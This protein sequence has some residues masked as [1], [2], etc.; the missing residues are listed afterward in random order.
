MAATASS[1]PKPN[2]APTKA[3]STTAVESASLRECQAL[4][5]KSLDFKRFATRMV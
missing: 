5:S 1:Q 2:C 4:A 3:T